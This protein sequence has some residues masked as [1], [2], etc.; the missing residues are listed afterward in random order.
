MIDV[1][2]SAKS[3]SVHL[4]DMSATRNC[5]TAV[6]GKREF[7]NTRSVPRIQV[8]IA[9]CQTISSVEACGWDFSADGLATQS[10]GVA[11]KRL[12]LL[13]YALTEDA[14]V[15]LSRQVVWVEGDHL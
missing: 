8:L 6:R 11:G 4:L 1:I 12:D 3:A 5:Q 7:P 13:A 9:K 2:L 14:A 10:H 15:D